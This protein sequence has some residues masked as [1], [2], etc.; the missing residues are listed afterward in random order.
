MTLQ[1][2]LSL[3]GLSILFTAVHKLIATGALF[4][5][6]G[7]LLLCAHETQNAIRPPRALFGVVQNFWHDTTRERDVFEIRRTRCTTKQSSNIEPGDILRI[8]NTSFDA[9]SGPYGRYLHRA[10][11]TNTADVS[12]ENITLLYRPTISFSRLVSHASKRLEIAM[13]SSLSENTKTLFSKLI[14]GGRQRDE[15]MQNQFQYAGVSHLLARSG[16]HV[17]LCLLLWQAL[18]AIVPLPIIA[19]HLLLILFALL[20]GLLTSTS[21]SFMRAIYFFVLL[22][23]RIILGKDVQALHV[24]TLICLCMLL[25]NPYH[26]FFLDFQLTF[27]LTF[28]FAFAYRRNQYAKTKETNA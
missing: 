24:L 18:F 23:A 21:I 15:A 17:A 4:F 22:Q 5:F 8:E 1:L 14:L 10:G 13:Q 3:V 7:A 11:I 28:A 27:A 16:L 12:Q 19:R 9:P 20:Y 2:L 6:S 25:W 26:L